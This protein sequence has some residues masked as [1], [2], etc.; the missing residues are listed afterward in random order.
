MAEPFLGELRTFSFNFAPNGWAMCN[1]QFL[2]IAQNQALFALLGTTYG[3]NGTTTFAL[4]NVQGRIMIGFT[5]NF[6]QGQVGGEATHTL[7]MSEMPQH[8]HSFNVSNAAGTAPNPSGAFYA[9]A[10]SPEKLYTTTGPDSSAQVLLPAGGSQPHNNMQPFNVLNVCI[11][12]QGIFPSR[13]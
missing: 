1:G 3:G 5:A 13:N 9:A 11:A 8:G 4:P 6:P 12:L 2:A 7:Q 10:P